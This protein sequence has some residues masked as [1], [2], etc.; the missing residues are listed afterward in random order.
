LDNELT[1]EEMARLKQLDSFKD[2]QKIVAAAPHFK[3]PEFDAN[4]TFAKI[5]AEKINQ[6]NNIN[7]YSTF[8]KI[9][10]VLIVAVLSY[11]YFFKNSNKEFS[12]ATAST[13]HII[14]PD[15]SSVKLNAGSFLTYNEGS[16]KES[17]N[18]SLKGEAFFKVAKG[19]KFSVKTPI[20]T[21]S[22][23]GTQFNVKQR[24]DLLIVTCYEG[25]V[26]VETAQKTLLVSA[27]NEFRLINNTS[28]LVSMNSKKPSWLTGKSSFASIPLEE[29]F[30]ELER[31]Y[32][33][34]VSLKNL[35]F[36]K[37]ETY[38]GSFVHNNLEDAL[39]ATTIPFNL[40]YKINGSD[41]T[42]MKSEL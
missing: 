31:Q 30:E 6:E 21:I 14:L 20:G 41:V 33:I 3:A 11:T 7:W 27:G 32:N 4:K 25:L 34:K 15:E 10:A 23:K 13:E 38:T 24:D 22:V 39:K 2:Y 19:K 35:T 29:V 28:A 12:T 17:R 40:T 1:P 16:W 37:D 5:Q 18:L 36:G 42:I 9:A 8:A 26:E